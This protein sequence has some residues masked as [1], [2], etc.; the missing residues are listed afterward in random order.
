MLLIAANNALLYGEV[1]HLCA[2]TGCMLPSA[3]GWERKMLS[4]VVP[5]L[6]NERTQGKHKSKLQHRE[7]CVV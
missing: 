6:P 5:A 3:V 7:R 2:R 1:L 4:S